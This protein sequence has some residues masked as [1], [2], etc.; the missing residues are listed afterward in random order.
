MKFELGSVACLAATWRRHLPVVAASLLAATTAACAAP[1]ATSASGGQIYYFADCQAGATPRC[2]PG[3]NANNG[4]SPAS[5]KRD[6]RGFDVNGL[7]AGSQVLFAAGGAW[8]GFGLS[9]RNLNVT[10]QQP[11]MFGSYQASWSNQA[12]PLLASG[13]SVFIFG[14]YGDTV[15]DGGYIFRGLKLQGTNAKGAWG[16]FVHGGTRDVRIEDMEITGFEVGVHI[17]Q[18]AA[19]NAGLTIRNSW[20]HANREHGVLGD[21]ENLLIEGTLFERN[22]F[23]GSPLHHAI[24]LGGRGRNGVLRGNTFRMNSV[25]DGVCAGGNLT[26]HGQWTGL[27]IEGNVLIQESSRPT[28]YGISINGG[29][30]SA[31]WFRELVVRDNVIVN[32]GGCAICLTSAPGAVVENNRVVH[33]QTTPH[34]A[35]AMPDRRPG[36][37]DDADQGAVVRGNTVYMARPADGSTAIV[38]RGGEGMR[39]ENNLAIFGD[40]AGSSHACFWHAERAAYAAFDGNAC[41]AS[42]TRGRWSHSHDRLADARRAGFDAAGSADRLTLTQVPTAQNGWR[43]EVT[44]PA[45]ASAMR[46][47]RVG[48]CT[49]AGA[50]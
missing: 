35:I 2:V 12:K 14:R 9:V 47:G 31:E 5:P 15:M 33:M 18:G 42:T 4:T 39:V 36:P 10:S 27:L 41:V 34:M 32:L 40:E 50:R 44:G 30:T 17:Q 8:A 45:P 38:V 49:L 29:Y 28:C 37:G 43:C 21:A 16:L 46:S 20:I 6:L 25:V 1:D 26:V 13:G 3:D 24:Y 11:L 19:P 7:P 48:A 23:S 22:N